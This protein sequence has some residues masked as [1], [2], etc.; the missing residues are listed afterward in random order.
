MAKQQIKR[1]AEAA[2]RARKLADKEAK[3]AAA[4]AQ[5]EA[6]KASF[7]DFWARYPKKKG[8]DYAKGCWS[9]ALRKAT[10]EQI[11]AA[12]DNYVFTDDKKFI[13]HPSSWLNGACWLDEQ[14]DKTDDYGLREW[15]AT[16]TSD[17]TLSAAMY[18]PD[19]LRPILIVTGWEPSWRGSLDILNAWMRDGYVPDSIA[20]TIASAV[21]EFGARGTLAAFDKR[22]RYRAER[23]TL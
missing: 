17:G 23:I 12:L 10:V 8:M 6:D 7:R 18:D 21:A 19:D 11:L 3:K 4:A 22:V 14:P 16:I 13:P 1:D 9:R 20:K 2:E 15:H 5:I